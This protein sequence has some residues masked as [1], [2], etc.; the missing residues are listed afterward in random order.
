MQRP[1]LH[2]WCREKATGIF[3]EA[4]WSSDVYHEVS[5]SFLV[6]ILY[7]VSLACH[8]YYRGHFPGRLCFLHLSEGGWR[9]KPGRSE[10]Q[11]G[12]CS[13]ASALQL[14]VNILVYVFLHAPWEIFRC[15][16][17]FIL[18]QN[19]SL[20]PRQASNFWPE[21]TFMRTE[22]GKVMLPPQVRDRLKMPLT[23]FSSRFSS[24][25]YL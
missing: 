11:V 1:S 23:R 7:L 10:W 2:L 24:S 21:V 15:S 13:P 25:L 22:D 19:L 9:W 20:L 5:A 12:C 18:R 17:L 16:L 8:F 3:R 4:S 14:W 6:V